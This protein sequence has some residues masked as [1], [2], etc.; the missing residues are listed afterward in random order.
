MLHQRLLATAVPPGHPVDLGA[1]LVG[2]VHDQEEVVGE[3]VDKTVGTLPHL[4]AA[5]VEGVVLD[6]GTGADLQHHLE[7]EVGAALQA[8]SLQKPLLPPEDG[9]LTIQLSPDQ[10]HDLLDGLAAGHVVAGRVDRRPVQ[11]HEDLPRQG[12]EAGDALHLVAPQLHTDRLLLVGGEDLHR[13]PPH[14]ELAALEGHVV[15]AVM[16]RDQA[17]EDLLARGLL[18]HL[19]VHHQIA[20]VLGI[21]QAVDARDRRHDDHVLPL[22]QRRSGPQAE[23][24]DVLVDRGVLLYVGVG[25]GDVRLGLV[26]V[27]V[28]YEVFDGMGGKERLQ[29]TI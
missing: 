28:R 5:G 22:H 3:V 9:Q 27:V 2:L 25:G 19:E 24:L 29:L 23:T 15:P 16:D 17:T 10:R 21:T 1:G 6:A 13:V 12:I 14:P 7:I 26:V 4:S 18:S 11:L 20:V 8:L